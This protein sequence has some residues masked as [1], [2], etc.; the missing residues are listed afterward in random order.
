MQ[1]NKPDKILITGTPEDI[2]NC[3]KS[4]TGFYLK[5]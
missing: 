4:K 3:E 2:V 5:G 1:N